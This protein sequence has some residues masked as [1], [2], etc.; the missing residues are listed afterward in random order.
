M[1]YD[2]LKAAYG[3]KK[4]LVRIHC[5]NQRDFLFMYN[6]KIIYQNNKRNNIILNMS[7]LAANS[8]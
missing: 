8:P 2:D 5:K 7:N 6:I 1:K 4:F 3:I